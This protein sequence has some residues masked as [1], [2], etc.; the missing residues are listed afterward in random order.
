MTLF[1][2]HCEIA[3][4]LHAFRLLSTQTLTQQAKKKNKPNRHAQFR[5]PSANYQGMIPFQSLCQTLM[6][7]RMAAL[8]AYSSTQLQPHSKKDKCSRER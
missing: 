7:A 8:Q 6:L 5:L 2:S 1:E 3:S 4:G